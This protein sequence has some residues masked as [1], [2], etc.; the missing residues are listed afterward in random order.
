MA[1]DALSRILLPSAAGELHIGAVTRGMKRKIDHD[2]IIIEPI[3]DTFQRPRVMEDGPRKSEDKV[4]SFGY[5]GQNSYNQNVLTIEVRIGEEMKILLNKIKSVDDMWDSM[6]DII[7]KTK[8]RELVITRGEIGSFGDSIGDFKARFT[9]KFE[10]TDFY[11]NIITKKQVIEDHKRQMEII[12]NFHDN[13]WSGHP[14]INRTCEKIAQ[15]YHWVSMKPQIE[16]Y[17]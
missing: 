12:K 10:G 3:V 1:V 15:F 9:A 2:D 14:G 11:L 13:P 4:L 5:Q 17:V 6:R 7:Q 16:Q 8:H